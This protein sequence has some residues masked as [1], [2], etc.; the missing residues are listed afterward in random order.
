MVLSLFVGCTEQASDDEP[1]PP[2]LTFSTLSRKQRTSKSV[3]TSAVSVAEVGKPP[4]VAE[5]HSIAH[6]GEH[7]LNLVT[8]VP[9]PGV[10]IL[11][12]WF[13]RNGAILW[14]R[15]IKNQLKWHS[16][17]LFFYFFHSSVLS[18]LNALIQIWCK[19]KSACLEQA[20]TMWCLDLELLLSSLPPSLHLQ[21]SDGR[22]LLTSSVTSA[23][24]VS[25]FTL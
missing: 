12:H 6:A 1:T 3:S 15:Q 2:K 7:K 4:D 14:R 25:F 23:V 18:G 16:S 17:Y 21:A 20:L 5:A 19:V 24:S 9:S 8:P 11:L 22:S 13:T 10:F